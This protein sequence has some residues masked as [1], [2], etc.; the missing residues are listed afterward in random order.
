MFGFLKG[1]R[2]HRPVRAKLGG[3]KPDP[4]GVPYWKF[5]ARKLSFK[6]L[7]L[8]GDAD[9]RQYTSPRHNQRR[10]STCVGQS[11]IKALEIK[12][13]MKYGISKHVDLSILDIYYGA[14]DLMN[15]K[16]TDTDA[17]THIYLACDVL[18]RYGVCREK[19]H[20]FDVSKMF[21]APSVLAT[22]EAR[23]NQIHSH[24]KLLSK[25][26]DL[27]DDIILNLRAGNPVI[28]GTK[29]GENWQ[30]YQGGSNV[31]GVNTKSD[32]GGHAMVIVGW[33][34]GKFI[35]ENSWGNSWG[36][37]GFAWV[38]PEVFTHRY[39]RDLWVIVTGSETWFEKR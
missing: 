31:I 6:P 39:T 29:V 3:W 22:R 18:R 35:V 7:S 10:T 26:N 8:Y 5:D 12:R 23:L 37:D 33:V 4:V 21:T 19:M 2:K 15:P 32:G 27:I 24:F 14:R 20:P 34:N 16:M 38:A 17:G 1:L 25:G 30:G 28:F 9:L 36:N 13:I 11:T